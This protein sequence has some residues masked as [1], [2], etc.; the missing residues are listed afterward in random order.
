ML[1]S[2]GSGHFANVE[3]K[4]TG[5]E[6]WTD[7]YDPRYSLAFL[8]IGDVLLDAVPSF[9]HSCTFHNGFSLTIGVFGTDNIEIDN[10]VIHHTVGAGNNY[11]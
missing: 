4:L 6:G 5:Q 2:T 11:S 1:Y 9:V 3:F 10:N 7:F 8:D